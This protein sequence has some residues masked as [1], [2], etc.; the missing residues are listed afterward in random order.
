ML[1]TIA[2]ELSRIYSN[3]TFCFR[4]SPNLDIRVVVFV[5]CIFYSNSKCIIFRQNASSFA[6]YAPF[7]AFWTIWE[8]NL[9]CLQLN[10][11]PWLAS[12]ITQGGPPGAKVKGRMS[13]LWR[14]RG[15]VRGKSH[16]RYLQDGNVVSHANEMTQAHSLL[17]SH[18]SHIITHKYSQVTSQLRLRTKSC[19]GPVS[20]SSQSLEQDEQ[21]SNRFWWGIL[22]GDAYLEEAVHCRP[23]LAVRVQYFPAAV[24]NAHFLFSRQISIW[25][26]SWSPSSSWLADKSIPTRGT[27]LVVGCIKKKKKCNKS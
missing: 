18:Y 24:R 26:T 15:G 12:K 5:L 27:W 25:N 9:H 3:P 23:P 10:V 13:G 7:S 6:I 16:T 20:Y 2:T 4:L 11:Q 21:T 19:D 1:T 17:T 14:Y 8:G 22:I